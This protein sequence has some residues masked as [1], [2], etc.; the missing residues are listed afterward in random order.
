[1]SYGNC[2]NIFIICQLLWS[3]A[4]AKEFDVR[5]MWYVVAIINY[6]QIIYRYL[7]PF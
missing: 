3:E 1:M 6:R 2:K 7:Y 4:K 5:C